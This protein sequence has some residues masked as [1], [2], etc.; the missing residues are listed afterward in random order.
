[1]HLN[2]NA[3][4]NAPAGGS[5][6]VYIGNVVEATV[7]GVDLYA[8][9]QHVVNVSPAGCFPLQS[10]Y[11]WVSLKLRLQDFPPAYTLDGTIYVSTSARLRAM[12]SFYPEDMRALFMADRAQRQLL[13]SARS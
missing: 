6:V 8:P 9:G 3:C 11:N 13:P 4:D 1:M 7:A 12:Q 10:F 5:D 2:A